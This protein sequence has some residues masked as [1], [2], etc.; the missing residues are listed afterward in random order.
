MKTLILYCSK[1][2]GNTKRLVDAIEEEYPDDVD[3]V[4]ATTLP[5]DGS[6]DP[7]LS[8]YG[9][10]GLASGIYDGAF[11]AS[12][13]SAAERL[14]HFDDQVFLF[15]T[16][17]SNKHDAGWKALRALCEERGAHVVGSFGCTGA[18]TRA[19][20]MHRAMSMFSNKHPNASDLRET[21]KFYDALLE[22]LEGPRDDDDWDDE[23]WDD[24]DFDEDDWDDDHLSEAENAIVARYLEG[25]VGE[26]VGGDAAEEAR[27]SEG[28]R[29][30]GSG[31]ASGEQ[32]S[33]DE[34]ASGDEPAEE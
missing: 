6:G 16:S 17:S 34:Q 24:D 13:V 20:V 31:S 23:D 10:V 5:E 8:A 33:G 2:N 26:D 30:S 4:D 14:L 21:V 1:T 11:D 32:V 7:D 19:G 22:R 25:G 18:D 15:S 3:A 12:V 28:E 29:I 27:A 9:L